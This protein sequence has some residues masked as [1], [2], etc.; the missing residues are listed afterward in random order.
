[1]QVLP[2]VTA[3]LNTVAGLKNFVFTP[4]AL[5]GGGSGPPVQFVILSTEDP[6]RVAQVGDELVQ[7]A[8][9]SG[10]FYFADTDLKFD[11][12]QVD[13][14]I[15]RN[16]AADLGVNMQQVA[17]DVGSML[18]GGYVNYFNIQGNSYKVI[19]QVVRGSRLNPEQLGNYY[20][21]TSGGSL[22]PLSTFAK[23]KYRC[24]RSR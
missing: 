3:K 9:K 4:P 23:I 14:Q 22:V 17:A 19:P 12:P 1:M 11:Q 5:P 7:R 24:N 18:G 13:I 16:K 8:L 10:L 15:D 21:G 2:E 20:V 6:Q